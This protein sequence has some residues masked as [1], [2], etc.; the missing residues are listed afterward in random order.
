ML[1]S[2]GTLLILCGFGIMGYG[3]FI[4]YAWLPIFYGLFG[5]EIGLLLGKWLT[6]DIGMIAVML[7]AVGAIAAG[8][9]AYFLE[10]Y[11]RVLLGY[12]GGAVLALATASVIGLDR[13][14]SGFFGAIVAVVGGLIGVAVVSRY[15]DW[16]VIAA[17][18]LGGATLVVTGGQLLL[19]RNQD[20][21][22]W[23]T[24]PALLTVILAV[25]GARWQLSNIANWVPGRS[26]PHGPFANPTGNSPEQRKP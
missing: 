11:R 17:S 14:I 18:A 22:A 16:F 8:A 25:L 26:I 6:G 3:L 10:P 24:L 5:L 7:G 23:S 1:F 13:V 4:F 15:F 21:T 2:F 20:P 9:A 12:A 19:P